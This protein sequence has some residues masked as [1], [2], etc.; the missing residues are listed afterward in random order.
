MRVC[1]CVTYRASLP[2]HLPAQLKKGTGESRERKRV[3]AC[4]CV[5]VST[6]AG[7][8]RQA[9]C[10]AGRI[11]QGASNVKIATLE[12]TIAQVWV[13]FSHTHIHTHTH[14]HT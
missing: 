13:T 8:V 1:V 2:A 10:N 3:R 5:C 9:R 4:M 12:G 7:R 14:T 6:S 11:S